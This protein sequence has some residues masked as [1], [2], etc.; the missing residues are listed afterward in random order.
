MSLC[1]RCGKALGWLEQGRQCKAC[2]DFLD[3]RIKRFWQALRDVRADGFMSEDEEAWLRRQQTE[4]GLTDAD[5]AP[6]LPMIHRERALRDAKLGRLPV[7]PAPFILESG[8][9]A[10]HVA[11]CTLLEERQSQVFAFSSVGGRYYSAGIGRSIPI[12]MMGTVG[13]GHFAITNL[14]CAFVG[15][16]T[17]M[18]GLH[19]IVSY[20]GYADGLRLDYP[21]KTA[22]QCF[23]LEDGEMACAIL[24][25]ALRRARAG[26]L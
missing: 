9:V 8:E 22:A 25:W 1:E 2:R 19:E 15:V 24:D 3:P 20:Q 14:R 7:V 4:L 6:C 16:R 11:P 10:H 18:V 23:K 21:N 5:V 13:S 12:Q 17:I 26:P